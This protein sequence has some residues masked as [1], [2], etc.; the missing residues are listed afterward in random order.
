MQGVGILDYVLDDNQN[1]DCSTEKLF[2]LATF[3]KFVKNYGVA[4]IYVHNIL[5]HT[6]EL[7]AQN[8]YILYLLSFLRYTLYLGIYDVPLG[9][10]CQCVY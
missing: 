6:T 3:A 10:Y 7:P 1:D 5:N 2:G 8:T 4:I 9:N